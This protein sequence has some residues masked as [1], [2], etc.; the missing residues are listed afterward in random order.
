MNT[1]ANSTHLVIFPWIFLPYHYT[2]LVKDQK[3]NNGKSKSRKNTIY[4]SQKQRIMKIF[5]SRATTWRA[6]NGLT[7]ES[8]ASSGTRGKIALNSTQEVEK[9]NNKNVI[10]LEFKVKLVT[11]KTFRQIYSFCWTENEEICNFIHGLSDRPRMQ[12]KAM[13]FL[14]PQLIKILCRKTFSRFFHLRPSS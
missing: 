10:V 11:R 12:H 6:F 2:D 7:E 3:A 5:E 14:S 1:F 8:L 9:E 4:F 13:E